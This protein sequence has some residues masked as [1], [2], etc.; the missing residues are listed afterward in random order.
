MTP[1]QRKRALRRYLRRVP[2]R[3]TRPWLDRGY[4]MYPL[5]IGACLVL[6]LTWE[7]LR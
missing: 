7:W 2:V 1:W 3:D 4:V 5:A 6:Y